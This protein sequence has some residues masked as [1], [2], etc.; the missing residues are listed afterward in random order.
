MNG[1]YVEASNV[2]LLSL[3]D[4]NVLLHQGSRLPRY[5]VARCPVCQYV[6]NKVS[7]LVLNALGEFSIKQEP[8]LFSVLAR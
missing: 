5:Q 6:S 4:S 8:V 3:K 1:G 2:K 7:D